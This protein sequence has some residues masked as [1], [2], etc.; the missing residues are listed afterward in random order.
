MRISIKPFLL[1]LLRR[2]PMP[3]IAILV[4]LAVGLAVWGLLDQIQSRQVAKIFGQELQAQLYQRARE[5]L[6]RFD[7]YVSSYGSTTRLL[8]NHRLLSEYLDPLFWS[9]D[10]A[11]A[12]LLYQQF[13]PHWL[14][15]FFEREA[16]SAPSHVILT[17]QQGRV[18]EIFQAGA[19][20]VPPDLA[21]QVPARL[22]HA[23]DVRSTIDRLGDG[24]YLV[25]SDAVEDAGGYPMGYLVVLVPI[26][27]A[28]LASSQRG[29]FVGRAAV[30]LVDGE[31]QRII[32]SVDSQL[33]PPATLVEQWS[34]S[35]LV[36]SQSMPEYDGAHSN[37]LFATF[38]PHAAVEKMSR[39][40]QLLEQ[41]QRA[42]AAVVYIL[43]FTA[44][45]YLVS[46]RLNSVLKRMTRFSQ[47]ALGISEP[48]FHRGG[49]QLVLLEEWIRHFTQLV[50]KAREEM[51]MQHQAEMR[52]SEALK[53]AVME[54]SLDAIVTLDHDG[55]IIELNPA[56]ERVFGL[57]RLQVTGTPFA[58]HFLPEIARPAFQRLLDRSRHLHR[59]PQGRG[60][61][62][63]L[64]A[65]GAEIPV[66][67]SIAPIDLEAERFYTLYIHDITARKQAEREIKS[68]ARF[69][70]ESPNPILRVSAAGNIVYANRASRLLLQGWGSEPG[71]PLPLEW[72]EQVTVALD[73]G[74]P[75]EREFEVSG[76]VYS[77]L[78]APIR[79]LG[80][81]NIYARDI[82]AVRRAEQEAR[83]HQAELVHVCRLSTMGEMA[84]GMAHELNQ[85][86]SAIVNY[87]NGCSRRLQSGASN[88]DDLVAA[89]G[90]ITQ[91]AQRASEII[92]R[93][94]ALVGKQAAI[95]ADVDL[96]HL[97]REVC[98]FVEFETTRIG[99][100]IALDLSTA[101]IPVN[102]DLVQIEQ[103]LL[104][105]VRNA[106]D[107]LQEV[108][109]T[110]RHLLIRTWIDRE[111]WARVAVVDSGPGIRADWLRH[112][113]HPFFTTKESG[114]GMGLAISQ[115]IIENHDGRIW[116]ES[117]PGQ[118]ST[119]HV[120]LPLLALS[121]SLEEEPCASHEGKGDHVSQRDDARLRLAGADA[122]T[123][124]MPG[125]TPSG[126]PI[127]TALLE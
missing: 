29:I 6:I 95:R 16:L 12:P 49:N 57:E 123:A 81:L 70:S 36:T 51:S 17:D 54:A 47:R 103:V 23:R 27:D 21:T 52:E 5:S 44:L 67:I 126:D 114:M 122:R 109:E 73:S 85:P 48:G 83:Q 3:V 38:I 74:E 108:S 50:L 99:L 71:E 68:L 107:A 8:A 117:E 31:D 53:A 82:T 61:L 90:Q 94:R 4:G 93:L 39:H 102:V 64:R 124:P 15:D 88:P 104:N 66:E 86:L 59:E 9:G 121:E 116:A 14:P 75:Q 100:Q 101:P 25:S 119:F 37:V 92:R 34:D 65:D 115:T 76:Q 10:E 60:E 19:T 106:T 30:A 2:V 80:Y 111:G 18:R 118:G 13:R 105:L 87:A 98:S 40:V 63:A 84:T 42:I 96:N 33:L 28:F 20:P 41:R 110:Q 125:G 77:L 11:P 22:L 69:A 58:E 55:R 35:Y 43:V 120:A 56:A 24:L 32:V 113:F 78:F 91:Q 89:M 97:V 72:V 127:P 112:L 46:S 79:D 26:D 1:L 62:V 45:I 7:R